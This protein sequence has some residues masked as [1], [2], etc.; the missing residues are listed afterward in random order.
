MPEQPDGGAAEGPGAGADEEPVAED[1]PAAEEPAAGKKTVDTVS[2]VGQKLWNTHRSTLL[3]TASTAQDTAV[4]RK[5]LSRAGRREFEHKWIARAAFQA[6]NIGTCGSLNL[7][8]SKVTDDAVERL[9]RVLG[10]SKLKVINLTF[11]EISDRGAGLLAIGL[12]K[13][14]TVVELSLANNKIGASSGG[15]LPRSH[16]NHS[17]L[18]PPGTSQATV[19]PG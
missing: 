10:T 13:N 17:T 18:S 11:N 15:N 7:L 12:R 4:A 3:A 9:A 19:G 2:L 5:Q 6:S 14:H 8:S 16:S 1:E